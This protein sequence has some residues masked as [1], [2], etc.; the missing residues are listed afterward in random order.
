MSSTDQRPA[1]HWMELAPGVRFDRTWLQAHTPQ[2][3]WQWVLARTEQD[4]AVYVRRIQHA[5]GWSESEANRS[6]VTVRWTETVR[7]EAD[8]A[9]HPSAG[10]ADVLAAIDALNPA[11]RRVLARQDGDVQLLGVQA[12]AATGEH[13]RDLAEGIDPRLTAATDWP[14]LAL[15]LDRAAAAGVDVSGEL[16]RLAAAAPLPD[17]HPARELHWRLLASCEAA[18]PG[19]PASGPGV[20]PSA[21]CP[22]ATGPAASQPPGS[23]PGR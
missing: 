16:V 23:A 13:W 5:A 10:V 22:P 6:P 9:V 7:C 12:S 3:L 19:P 11:D 14:P 1:P 15:A 20:Q 21:S 2:L 8:V 4:R 17:R 18:A